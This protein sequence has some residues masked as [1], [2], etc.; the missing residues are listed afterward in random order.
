MSFAAPVLLL[1]LLAVPAAVGGYVWLERRRRRTA[2]AWAA[3]ALVPNL[4][5]AAP[6][7]RRH[8][9]VILALAGVTLLL[10]G[11]ARPKATIT[12]KRHEATVIIVL[13][14][15]GS[16][17]AADVRPSRLAAARAAAAQLIARVPKTY[18]IGLLTFAD[19]ASPVAPP[20]LDRT[21]VLAALGRARAGPEGTAL[22]TALSRGVDAADAVPVAGAAPPPA[23]E[24][25]LSD[26]G[27]T[28]RGPTPQQVA[29]K[30][31]KAHVPIYAAVVG[32]PDGV[33][34]QKIQGGYTEQFN[35]PAESDVLSSVARGSG[36]R[37]ST[38]LDPAFLRRAVDRLGTRVGHDRKAV[39]VTAVAAGGGLALM[40]AGAVLGGVWFR[41]VP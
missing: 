36:G 14:V 39:E 12:E 37:I 19:H 26:G 34:R 24:I 5:S 38:G 35:V 16:M 2:S 22:T 15:S 23:V 9:P 25:I 33:V 11:F 29:A 41:R 3:P 21:R 1:L 4:V 27:Q 8:V 17:A 18:R 6:G 30:A 40:L 13:D 20:S 32:T 31:A 28:A 7:P 10:V